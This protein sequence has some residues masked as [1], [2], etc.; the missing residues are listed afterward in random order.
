VQTTEAEITGP[1]QAKIMR[2]LKDDALCGVDIMDRL[3]LKS[4][5]TIYPVLKV[6][7][8]RGLVDY[9]VEVLGATRKKIYSLTDAGRQ[10]IREGFI[11]SAKVYCCDASLLLDRTLKTIEGLVEIKPH[12]KVLCTLESDEVRRF[13][14]S[15]DV[16]FSYDLNVSPGTYDLALSFLGV[17]CFIGKET[18]DITDYVSRLYKSLKKGGYLLAIEIEKTDNIFAGMFFEDIVGL[19]ESAGLKRGELE[20]ILKRIGLTAT[21]VTSKSGLL[22]A[23]SQKT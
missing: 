6:L 20:D 1:L 23:T 19:K 7:R 5:G 18:A 17:G 16:T 3:N 10:L 11:R 15:A 22:Y 2:I 4:P 12:Q 21:K 8:K 14:R 13:L 9:K